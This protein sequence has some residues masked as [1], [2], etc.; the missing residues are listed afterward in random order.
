MN[1]ARAISFCVF[2]FVGIVVSGCTA[3]RLM[4]FSGSISDLTLDDTVRWVRQNHDQR[5]DNRSLQW[6]LVKEQVQA[7]RQEGRIDEAISL[8]KEHYPDLVTEQ[9]IDKLAESRNQQN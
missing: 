8:L 3:T 5:F 4:D 6:E 9:A 2:F 7:L 1:R